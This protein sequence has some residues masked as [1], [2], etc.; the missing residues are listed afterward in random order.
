MKNRKWGV[1]LVALATIGGAAQGQ[2]TEWKDWG[3]G[4]ARQNYSPLHQI[5]A[6]NVAGL[7]PVWVWD[8][9][10]FGRTWETRPLLIDGLLYLTESQS[11]DTIA[12]EPET[13]KLVWRAKPPVTAGAGLNR[14][15]FAYWAGDGTMKP[16]LVAVW[17]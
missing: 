3:G 13:G 2:V 10:K 7:K 17:G 14:R 11:G 8:S 12:L 15:S 6:A 5:T 4:S 16:R 9:G 1:M